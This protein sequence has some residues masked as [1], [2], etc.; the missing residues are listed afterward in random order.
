MS[1]E[2]EI[3]DLTTSSSSSSESD[4]WS[5]YFPFPPS[6]LPLISHLMKEQAS[7]KK[8]DVGVIN[9]PPTIATYDSAG[10][11]DRSPSRVA[12][13]TTRRDLV[14]PSYFTSD[15]ESENNY[16]EDPLY[17]PPSSSVRP[18]NRP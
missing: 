2:P 15:S 1:F 8:H 18:K 3:I 9:K 4:G 16:D 6:A 5:K 11:S 12:N 7:K 17:F 13:Q 14:S 10:L